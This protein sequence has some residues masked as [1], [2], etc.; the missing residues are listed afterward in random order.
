MKTTTKK[1]IVRC[2]IKAGPDKFNPS[3]PDPVHGSPPPPN[4]PPPPLPPI[5]F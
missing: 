4:L 5:D 2:G 3:P 1:L